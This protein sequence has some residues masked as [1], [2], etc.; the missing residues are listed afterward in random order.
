MNE[1]VINGRKIG[2]N[3]PVYIIAEGCDN[4]MGDLSVAKEMALQAKLAG[5]DCI[6]F[7]HHLPDEEMLPDV[8]MTSNFDIPLYEFLKLHALKLEDH[9]KLKEYCDK[10]GITYLC[11]PFSYKAA[12]ELQEAHIAYAFKI[13][14]GEMTD[15]PSLQKIAEFGKPMI[16]SCGM[17][18]LDEIERTYRTLIE[19]GVP[20]AFTN[21]LSEYPPLYEDINLGV[22]T[23]MKK[24]F[25]QA[26][27]GHSDHTPDLYTCYAA[28]A[29][30]ACIIEKH[31]ILNKLTPGPDQSVSIDFKELHELVDGVQKVKLALGNEKKVRQREKG[32]REWAFR[33]IVSL[34]D[35]EPGEIISNDMIWSKRPGTGIPSY[36]MNEIV[37]KS[38]VR[39]IKK[40][41]LITYEDLEEM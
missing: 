1:I 12:K 30:G 8:P 27:I 10:I 23:E 17:C 38:V 24:Q 39:A 18:T 16:I 21:C 5:A 7:Q 22:I 11:T 35:I 29:L 40:N 4:H 20:L 32:I 2:D 36:K 26:I 14:S 34:R 9:I 15:I 31:V 19:T 37:G 41:S 28:V 33:S 6:K 13:G 25:P 3:Q